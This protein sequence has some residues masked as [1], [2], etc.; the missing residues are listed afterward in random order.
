[1]DAKWELKLRSDVSKI[2]HHCGS[3]TRIVFV[4]SRSITVEKQ[5]KLRAEFLRSHR[6][7]LEIFEEG[8]FRVRLEE[9]H[10]D[11]A[12]KHLRVSV[13]ATPGFYVSQIK[14]QGLSDENQEEVLRHTSADNLR[15]TLTAQVKADPTNSG[16]WKALA[17]VCNYMSDY[18][19]ALF[20]VS[21]AIESTNEKGEC[22]NLRALKASIRAEQ[23]KVSGSRLLLRSAE[24]Q[25]LAIVS[26]IGRSVDF[27]NLANVQCALGKH[28]IA[29]LNYRRCLDLNPCC[30]KAWNNL[31]SLLVTMQREKEGIACFD[32]ALEL[33]PDMLEAIVTKAN[34]LIIYADECA[35]ALRLMERAFMLDGDL[36]NRWSHVHYWKAVALCRL[37]RLGEA[38]TI[39]EDQLERKLDCPYL[40]RLAAD[41]L[42]KLWRS[43]SS[44]VA[45]A[46]EFFR[47]RIDPGERDHRALV[48]L[49]DLLNASERDDEA[50]SVFEDFLGVEDLSIKLIG[51]RV[52]ISISDLASSLSSLEGYCQFRRASNL[53]DY[54]RMLQDCSLRPHDEVSG[55]LFYLLLSV[56]FKLASAL[57]NFRSQGESD[58]ELN[59]IL[60][61][62]QMVSRVFASFGGALMAPSAPQSIENQADLVASAI[63]VGQE[64]PLVE[65]SRL[66]GFLYAAFEREIP[67]RYRKS[68]VEL[69]SSIHEDWCEHFIEAVG[70]DWDIAV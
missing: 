3:I 47:M 11:L 5:D 22:Y 57:P 13:P 38:L 52:L 36:E 6:I 61:A 50:W 12:L 25:F 59:L 18:K 8:W 2:L 60:D 46:E 70:F 45:K 65:F 20:C 15:A 7:D 32:R 21:K 66:I 68:I 4:S 34:V 9:E 48:E 41:I 55:V 44:Y 17:H 53:E 29:E 54:V 58:S 1:M 49:L 37:G 16:A 42:A 39:V 40:G 43:D 19:H 28:A 24:V 69:S 67:E 51:G 35:E 30:A 63:V 62:Y 23:G 26:K 33:K 10:A 14:I 27:Y 31:G 64:V 56:Y